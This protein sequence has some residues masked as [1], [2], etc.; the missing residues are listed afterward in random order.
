MINIIREIQHQFQGKIRSIDERSRKRIYIDVERE[1]LTA[2]VKF[3]AKVMGARF[4]TA[5]G[6]HTPVDFEILYHFSF[7]ENNRLVSVRCH[8]D[9]TKPEVE[10]ISNIIEAAN[11]IEREMHEMLGINFV[12]HPN[13]KRLLLDDDWPPEGEYPLRHEKRK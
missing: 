3:L 5:T 1:S 4:I 10:T 13:L 7:D 2:L 9:I 6:I 12:G 8:L 11:W